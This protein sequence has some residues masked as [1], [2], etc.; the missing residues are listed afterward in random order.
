MVAATLESLLLE[1]PW[2]IVVAGVAAAV[3]LRMVGR[4]RGRAGRPLVIASW[5][6]FALAIGVNALAWA[7]TTTREALIER[8][9]MLVAATSPIDLAALAGLVESPALLLGPNGERIAAIDVAGI[10]E[11]IQRHDVVESKLRSVQAEGAG[12]GNGVSWIEVSSR[13][14]GY[15]QRSSWRIDWRQGDDSQWRATA[16]NWLRWNGQPPPTDLLR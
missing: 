14:N 10:D 1:D 5:V 6:M 4:R 16:F 15:P 12:Q 8:T 7:V 2:P 11:R 9:E 13:L 3:V